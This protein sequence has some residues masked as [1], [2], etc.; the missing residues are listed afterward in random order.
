[1]RGVRKG[2]TQIFRLAA[3]IPAGQMSIAKQSRGGVAERL[4][5]E[6]LVA[7]CRFAH[8]K[9]SALALL[10]FAANDGEGYDDPIPHIEGFPCR[11]PDLDDLAHRLMAHDVAG[12]HARHEMIVE[13][14][15]RA[16]DSAARNLDD[17]VALVLD[18]RIRYAIAADVGGAV[19]NE[20][21]HPDLRCFNVVRFVLS[22]SVGCGR[23][24][25]S[26]CEISTRAVSRRLCDQGGRSRGLS[27]FRQAASACSCSASR[28]MT[29]VASLV[30]VLSVAS[31]S[32]SVSCSRLAAS[33]MPSCSAQVRRVPYR[34]IS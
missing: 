8:G 23:S 13:M 2:D 33:D 19:P 29:E 24:R 26:C 31:S 14:E 16:A 17:R 25:Y 6:T 27:G 22:T 28:L 3:G 12:F 21:L 34:E 10:A 32:S 1:M 11:R 20:C 15:V 4:V 5:R 7:V 18:P 9:V 30:S